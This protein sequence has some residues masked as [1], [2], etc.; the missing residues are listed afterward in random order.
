VG[1]FA[2]ALYGDGKAG[3]G[4][5]AKLFKDMEKGKVGLE[6]ITKVIAYMGTLTREDLIAEML[7][8]PAKKMEKLKSQ[9]IRFLEAFNDAGFL[10]VMVAALEEITNLLVDLG[11]WIKANREDIKAWSDTFV[12]AFKWIMANLPLIISYFAALKVTSWVTAL[13]AATTAT[14]GLSAALLVLAKRLLLMPMLVGLAV[15]AFVEMYDTV[16][17]KN[18]LWTALAEQKDKGFLGYIAAITKTVLDFVTLMASGAVTGAM[19]L[20]GHLTGNKELVDSAKRTWAEAN[21][22]NIQNQEKMWGGG[23]WGTGNQPLSP[24][25]INNTSTNAN[26]GQVDRSFVYNPSIEVVISNATARDGAEIA[27]VIDERLKESMKAMATQ[28]M[29][30]TSPYMVPI[31]Q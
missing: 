29:A 20:L 30:R 15:A 23:W 28:A 9:W 18:T 27:K 7:K 10:D 4:D 13:M 25:A 14:G 19:S 3:S 6:E 1:I 11:K 16:S 5:K 17:G 26:S 31:P 2:D 8:S 24:Q 22:T 21:M 12:K